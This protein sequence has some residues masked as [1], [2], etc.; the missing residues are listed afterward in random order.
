MSEYSVPL[1][2]LV[3]VSGPSGSGK[4]T[5]AHELARAIPCPAVCRDE[6]KEGMVHAHGGEFQADWGDPLTQKTFP[7]FFDV[8]RLLLAA[9]V[10]VVGE[11]AFQDKNWRPNLL[12]LMELAQIR[13]VQCYTDPAVAKERISGRGMRTAHADVQLMQNID[14]DNRAL[15]VFD[16]VSLDVPS[17][18]VDTTDGYNPSL[19]HIVDFIGRA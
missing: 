19:A 17:I 8:L 9:G 18:D 16:R 13:I 11:A 15:E 2:T 3:I 7:V 4:T 5:L 10:S 6:I 14:A 1:P 12:P